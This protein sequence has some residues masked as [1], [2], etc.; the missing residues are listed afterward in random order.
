MPVERYKDLRAGA[1]VPEKLVDSK[2]IFR[3]RILN[4]RIDEVELPDGKRSSREV[5]EHAGAVV[6]IPVL[7]NGNIVLVRQYRHAAGEF[8]LELPAGKLDHEG[9]DPAG[10]AR[11]ELLE[12]THYACGSVEKL[13]DFYSSPGMT[14]EFMHMFV[15]AGL[16]HEKGGDCDY[17]EFIAIADYPLAEALAMIRDGRIRDA[18]TIAGIL[19]YQVYLLKK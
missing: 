8:L 16:K 14:D 4:L 12:E 1:S 2:G 10:C 6:V 17:D 9:E 15:A 11:R 13:F 7:D 18:K 3:G 19:Y 5:I